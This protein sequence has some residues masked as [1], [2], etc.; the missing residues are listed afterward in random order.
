MIMDHYELLREFVDGTDQLAGA[1]L[2]VVTN[3]TF[4]DVDARSRGF[5]L[6]PALMTRIMDDVRDKN[7]VNPIASLVRLS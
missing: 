3:S 7:L 4:L 6:Y 5:G 2:V 1:L